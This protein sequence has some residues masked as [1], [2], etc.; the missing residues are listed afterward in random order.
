MAFSFLLFPLNALRIYDWISRKILWYLTTDKLPICRPILSS[1]KEVTHGFGRKLQSIIREKW[2]IFNFRYITLAFMIG[3][4]LNKCGGW[5][6]TKY[7]LSYVVL[8]QRWKEDIEKKRGYVSVWME[9]MNPSKY[10]QMEIFSSPLSNFSFNQQTL[11]S[12]CDLNSG[13]CTL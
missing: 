12:P 6:L 3:F 8:E 7:M 11:T 2:Q 9:V 13:N 10:E 5:P 4:L 1:N